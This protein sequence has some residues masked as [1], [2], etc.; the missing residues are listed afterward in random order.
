MITEMRNSINWLEEKL[1]NS[2]RN[3][4]KIQVENTRVGLRK[5]EAYKEI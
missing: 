1:R 4:I 2:P 5:L 3:Q